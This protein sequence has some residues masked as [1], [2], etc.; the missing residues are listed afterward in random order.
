MAFDIYA[1]TVTY[2]VVVR[3]FHNFGVFA[4]CKYQIIKNS[5]ESAIDVTLG[6]L[7]NGW[8]KINYILMTGKIWHLIAF[9]K[10]NSLSHCSNKNIWLCRMVFFLGLLR[11]KNWQFLQ[12]RFGRILLFCEQLFAHPFQLDSRA[13]VNRLNLCSLQYDFLHET[14]NAHGLLVPRRVLLSNCKCIF[15]YISKLV[16]F[17]TSF[18]FGKV[19]VR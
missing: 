9:R 19:S 8:L 7:G 10:K 2:E 4:I 11:A 1:N 13:F 3:N 5:S 16:C 18:F 12:N 15:M 6:R 17:F 14:Q